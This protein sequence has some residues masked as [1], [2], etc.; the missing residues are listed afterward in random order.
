LADPTIPP[1]SA[2]ID[3]PSA[4]N[5]H[6]NPQIL[7][8]TNKRAANPLCIVT[9]WQKSSPFNFESRGCPGDS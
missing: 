4:R 7:N 5:L 3:P 6:N 9:A 2:G 8:V 1:A